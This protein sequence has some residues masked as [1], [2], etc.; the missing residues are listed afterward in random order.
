MGFFFPNQLPGTI[1]NYQIPLGASVV[2]TLFLWCGPCATHHALVGLLPGV[3]PHVD[4]QLVA[5]VEGLVAP[6]ASRPEARE[7]FA[8]PLV[9]VDLLNVPHQLLLLLVGGAAVYPATRLLV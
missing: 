3:D 9:D 8:L 7:V 1:A 4:E 5:G 2:L 6:Y